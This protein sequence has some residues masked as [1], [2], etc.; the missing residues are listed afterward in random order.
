MRVLVLSVLVLA[1]CGCGVERPG[2]VEA[3]QA[4]EKQLAA[5]GSIVDVT[6]A[7]GR[8]ARREGL[9]DELWVIPFRAA[10]K[11]GTDV[12]WQ[13]PGTMHYEIEGYTIP[14]KLVRLSELSSRSQEQLRKDGKVRDYG[15]NVTA[16][17]PAGTLYACEGKVV[18]KP[19]DD[20][21]DLDEVQVKKR[22]TCPS[23]TPAECYAQHGIENRTP[24][25]GP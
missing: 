22:G 20:R 11:L 8:L 16:P 3:R 10:V 18:F 25:R 4:V 17:L 7:P 24:D 9:P 21:Y 1:V 19:V 5:Y 6:F 23:G 2:E 14:G 15:G 12:C 13:T